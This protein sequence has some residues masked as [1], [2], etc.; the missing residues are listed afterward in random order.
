MTNR[1]EGIPSF[2]PAQQTS[3]A[4]HQPKID[5]RF[6]TFLDDALQTTEAPGI[7][8]SH[9]AQKRME[10][11]GIHL[12]EA[13]MSQLEEV[14]SKLDQKGARNSLIMYDDLSLIASV[15][16]RTIITA[17]KTSEM[18]EVTNIDSAI[19]VTK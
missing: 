15:Q 12:D 19:F 5:R 2:H 10:Q 7:K 17:S 1:I 14:F 9:H 3:K 18:S 11:R 6:S 16:N 8:V 4:G 13:D